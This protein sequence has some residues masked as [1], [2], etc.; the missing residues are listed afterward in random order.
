MLVNN[1]KPLLYFGGSGSFKDV[2]GTTRNVSSY[3]QSATSNG[4]RNSHTYAGVVRNFNYANTTDSN[5]YTNE[6]TSYIWTVTNNYNAGPQ[7]YAANGFTIF[8]GTGD[9]AVTADD[10]KLYTPVTL[11]VV[12]AQ[13]TQNSDGTVITLRTFTNNTVEDV[14]IKEI[15]LYLF[16]YTYGGSTPI[17]MIGRK[18]LSTPV[19]I[20]VGASYTFT[21]TIN[22][23]N[24]TFT[25]ADN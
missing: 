12:S 22:M 4:N 18:V 3:M 24:I 11:S 13:C 10:Y 2:S 7:D 1:F 17:V 5:S 23:N 21:W 6:Q 14:V 25:E 19:T 16:R 8:V 9:T 20:P 15:G